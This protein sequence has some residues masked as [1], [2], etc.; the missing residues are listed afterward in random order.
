MRI[1]LVDDHQLFRKGM[2]ALLEKM[3]DVT[4]V[5][6]ASNGREFLDALEQTPVDLVLLDLKMPVLD[7]RNTLMELQRLHPDVKVVFLTMDTGEETVLQCMEDGAHGFLPK[8]AHPDEVRLAI[9]TV[10]EKGLY[11]N[12]ETTQIMMRGLSQWKQGSRDS[13]LQLNEREML[14]LQGICQQ[15]TTA[16]MA[17]ELFLSPRTVEGYRRDLLEKTETKNSVGLVLFAAQNGWLNQWM[18]KTD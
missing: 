1:A 7:G 2:A 13:G 9:R 14:V 5:L 11:V 10:Q 16:Q 8:D 18:Q 4:L 6:E 15:K 3:E 12:V 17:E